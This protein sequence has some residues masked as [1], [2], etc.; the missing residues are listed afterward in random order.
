MITSIICL[1]ICF[2]CRL[3]TSDMLEDQHHRNIT[4]LQVVR[5]CR[6]EANAARKQVNLSR[7]PP[8][9]TASHVSLYHMHVFLGVVQNCQHYQKRTEYSFFVTPSLPKQCTLVKT[10]TIV[11]LLAQAFGSS[12]SISHAQLFSNVS[13]PGRS[14]PVVAT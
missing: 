5:R 14:S 11:T 1:I 10:M 6:R 2:T 3:F 7:Q 12:W 4:L 8:C 13:C 9:S